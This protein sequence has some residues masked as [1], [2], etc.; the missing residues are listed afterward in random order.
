VFNLGSIAEVSNA[1][2][3]PASLWL[4]AVGLAGLALNRRRRQR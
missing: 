3:E 1:V 2:P 4:S